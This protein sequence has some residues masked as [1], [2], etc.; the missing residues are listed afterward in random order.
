MRAMIVAAGLGTR[1]RPLSELLPKPALPIRGVPLIAYQL[2]LLRH[3][4]VSELAINVHHLPE[5][6][7]AAAER[8]C[9]AGLAVRFSREPELLGTGGGIR[10]LAGFL[11]ESDPCL[12]LGGDMILDFDLSALMAWHRAG[13]HA[14][15]LLLREDP[16]SARFGTI[17][18]D[19]EGRVRRVGDRFELGGERRAGVYAWANVLSPRIFDSLPARDAFSHL[20]DWWMPALAAGADDVRGHV[21]DAGSCLWEPVGTPAELLAANLGLRS[22]SYLDL[23]AAT[24]RA[25]ATLL[26]DPDGETSVVLGAGAELG[27]GA[28]LERAVVFER[29][30]VPARFRGAGG[31]FASGRWLQCEALPE[32]SA[33]SLGSRAP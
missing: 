10:R 23:A 8:W 31:V 21:A 15:T 19:A 13:D 2:A 5:R 26:E 9:P 16:R 6:L 28:H 22:L 18:V 20:D 3:H 17:G 29:E 1:M 33:A 12:V 11:R 14:A 25:G 24:Q 32:R 30:R 27:E 7:E 4:G